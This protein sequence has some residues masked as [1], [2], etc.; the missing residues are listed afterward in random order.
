ML[1]LPNLSVI[2]YGYFNGSFQMHTKSNPMFL[3]FTKF[4][5]NKTYKYKNDAH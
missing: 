4:Y 3:T 2:Q 1:Y 5:K